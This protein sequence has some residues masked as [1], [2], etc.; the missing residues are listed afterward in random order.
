MNEKFLIE[1]KDYIDLIKKALYEDL[2]DVGD[3]TSEPLFENNYQSVFILYS[4][5]DGILCGKDI[6]TEVFNQVDKKCMVEFYFN[7]RDL[8]KKGDKVARVKGSILSILKGERTSLNII[9]HLSGIATKTYEFNQKANGKVKIL[10][11]R[12]TIPG[13]RSLQKYAV[14]CGGGK[15]HRMGL[16]DMVLIKD[17]HIDASGGI[18]NAVD[19][20]RKKWGE[21]YKIEVE[22]RNMNEVKE[23]LSCNVDIIMLD[24]MSIDLM[25]EAVKIINKKFKIEASGNMTFDQIAEVAETGVDF[26]S[27]GELT[28]TIKAFDFSLKKE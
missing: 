2:L 4:K 25:K 5:N 9:S 27:F 22:T 17:N 16:Y 7:D 11:T 18:K 8:L 13:L 19:K 20:I 23:A 3:V 1:K 10:D 15:N 12:K 21:K 28:H 6:F 14:F 26:I 24:N